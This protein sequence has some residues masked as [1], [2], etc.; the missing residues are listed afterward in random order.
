MPQR[1][2]TRSN[3]R[4]RDRHKIYNDDQLGA[5]S[6]PPPADSPCDAPR[7]E[8]FY[9]NHDT[10]AGVCGSGGNTEDRNSCT[11]GTP[12]SI[13]P[14]AEPPV[15]VAS[16]AFAHEERSETDDGHHSSVKQRTGVLDY[17]HSRDDKVGAVSVEGTAST[18]REGEGESLEC[19][20]VKF[21]RRGREEEDSCCSQTASTNNEEEADT[22]PDS[23][24]LSDEC[25]PE[26]APTG[27]NHHNDADRD[28]TRFFGGH[29]LSARKSRNG[30]HRTRYTRRGKPAASDYE[31]KEEEDEVSG[32]SERSECW[33]SSSPRRP[34]SSSRLE[35]RTHQCYSRSSL[36][37]KRNT[38]I[39]PS[40]EMFAE[41]SAAES[42]GGRRKRRTN[43][44]GSK[45]YRSP[46]PRVQP[47]GAE[48]QARRGRAVSVNRSGDIRLALT[49]KQSVSV[50]E[51]HRYEVEMARLRRENQVL[52]QQKE[53]SAR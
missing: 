51:D 20:P 44:K 43:S 3:V 9:D 37:M 8:S 6:K 28:G 38:R 11:A 1:S 34:T 25:G 27:R 41:I 17:G 39:A 49:G 29:K 35:R 19:F 7:R 33:S 15:A 10:T 2:T 31:E 36:K 52:R 14:G 26:G 13:G 12:G 53:H 23:F 32:V 48:G 18:T 50:E 24:S 30:Q 22:L 40:E 21:R 5:I 45:W 16:H 4:R 47:R 42:S 46:P